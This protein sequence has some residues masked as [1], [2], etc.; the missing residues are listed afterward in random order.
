MKYIAVKRNA[1]TSA[2]HGFQ[3]MFAEESR[4]LERN[5]TL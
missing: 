1:S 5:I 2:G 3:L 4:A